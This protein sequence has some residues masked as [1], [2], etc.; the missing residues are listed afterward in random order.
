MLLE[1]R[2]IW[3]DKITKKHLSEA[4]IISIGS[5]SCVIPLTNIDS[6]WDFFMA[7]SGMGKR[8]KIV[9][10]RISQCDLKK[11]IKLIEKIISLRK[12][13]EIVANDWG[14]LYYCI[15]HKDL[16]GLHIGRQLCRSLFDC[17]WYQEILEN[18]SEDMANIISSH[19]YCSNEKIRTLYKMGIKGIEINAISQ[20]FD[21]EPLRNN[22]IEVAI[23]YD[24]YLLSC[25]R[26]CLAKKIIPDKNC[27]EICEDNFALYP[28]GKWLDYFDTKKP[29][30]NYEKSMLAGL[31]LSG[32][33]VIL[34]QKIDIKTISFSETD[35]I[36]KTQ[37][38]KYDQTNRRKK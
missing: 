27:K 12:A 34:P 21:F 25:G 8:L 33:K 6:N 30:N 18:E 5:E 2:I 37:K 7:L 31:S 23:H 35:T 28:S 36:I 4:D 16:I 11:T 10:P 19:P 24:D 1:H 26:E 9:T 29:F 20:R 17:P 22:N 13:I 32:K 3:I 15:E 14:I 38:G